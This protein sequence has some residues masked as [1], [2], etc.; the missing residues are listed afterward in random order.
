ML[1]AKS[2]KQA[3]AYQWN[4]LRA[5]YPLIHDMLKAA[6]ARIRRLEIQVAKQQKAISTLEEQVQPAFA[7]HKREEN[8]SE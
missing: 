5:Q 8:S 6:C 3:E 2:K 7:E 1:K 4:A